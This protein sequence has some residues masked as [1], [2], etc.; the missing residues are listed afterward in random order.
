M[1]YLSMHQALSLW[2]E[3]EDCY[4]EVNSYGGDTAEIYAYRMRS[5]QYSGKMPMYSE[6]EAQ[7]ALSL[8]N[9]L[10]LFC[11]RRDCKA[12]VGT[13]VIEAD[14]SSTIPPFSHRVHVSIE[15]NE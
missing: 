2:A 13:T 5:Q 1:I 15:R 4:N 7:V 14:N 6:D 9:L 11:S 12:K 8:T 3:F 10:R